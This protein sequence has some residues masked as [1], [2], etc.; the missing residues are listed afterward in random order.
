VARVE[1]YKCMSIKTAYQ[2]T[3]YEKLI[4]YQKSFELVIITY[5]ITKTYPKEEQFVLVPQMRRAAISVVANIVEGYSKTSRKE[6]NRF[7]EISKGSINELELFFKVSNKLQYFDKIKF[8]QI[9]TLI[10]E[11]K[12]LL[13]GYQ[14]SLKR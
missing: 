8:E 14:K 12:K 5:K 2:K 9:I 13:Y 11:V 10:I 3:G 4:V 1:E 7:L 6:L